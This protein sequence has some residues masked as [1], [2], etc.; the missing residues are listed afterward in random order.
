MGYRA[1][2]PAQTDAAGLRV[3]VKTTAAGASPMR[4]NAIVGFPTPPL[5]I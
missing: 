1:P 3:P 2:A 5:L 4:F